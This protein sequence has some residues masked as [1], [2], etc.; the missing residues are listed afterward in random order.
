[1]LPLLLL[2]YHH[3]QTQL[4]PARA[5]GRLKL[6]AP[7]PRSFPYVWS[8][9]TPLS[10][11]LHSPNV[12]PAHHPARARALSLPALSFV[13]SLQKRTRLCQATGGIPETMR[14]NASSCFLMKIR[15]LS[16]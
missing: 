14:R 11:P 4:D 16:V 8:V 9:V 2:T 7:R 12:N 3:P 6:K 1:M 5:P 10:Y 15:E 13:R